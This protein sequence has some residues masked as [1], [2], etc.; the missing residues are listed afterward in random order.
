MNI[1]EQIHKAGCI[2]GMNGI[3]AD[4]MGLG[5]TI[6]TIGLLANLIQRGVSG[7]YLVVVPLSTLSNWK[8]EFSN[9]APSIPTV[10]FHGS[11]TERPKLYK[12]VGKQ[13][14][15]WVESLQKNHKTMPVVITSYEMIILE[16][17]FLSR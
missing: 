15:V 17:N 8:R 5:K 3:L 7:P 4:E 11:K 9:F 6:Q 1:F 2:P 16:Y 14:E 10:V 13:H 12:L